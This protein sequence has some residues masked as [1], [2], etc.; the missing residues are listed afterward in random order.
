MA[1]IDCDSFEHGVISTAGGG[2][3]AAVNGAPTIVTGGSPPY[4][5]RVLECLT[6]GVAAAPRVQKNFTASSIVVTGFRYR[7]LTGA[8]MA[9]CQFGS[10][11]RFDLDT[12]NVIQSPFGFD[13]AAITIN[14]W[15]WL[16]MMLDYSTSAGNLLLSWSIDGV[17]QETASSGADATG[18]IGSLKLGFL[19]AQANRQEQFKDL[20]IYT[21]ST[22][23]Y[24]V[25]DTKVL[26]Y[27][28]N[29]VGT[30]NL[31]AATSTFFFKDIA[32]ADTALTTSE[33]TSYQQIDDVPLDADTDHVMLT[34]AT[35]APALPAHQATASHT[36]NP[37][38]APSTTLG[39][40][41]ADDI[42]IGV[43]TN[44][45]A[46]T[47]P[48]FAGT[49]SGGAWTLVDNGQL[50]TTGNVA[51]YWSR[52]T[53]N[54][55]GQTVTSSTTDSGSMCVGRYSGA[56][57]TATPIGATKI[58]SITTN[59]AN[60]GL[61]AFTTTTANSKVVLAVGCDD[62]LAV[63]TAA[64]AGGNAL[65][66]R[67]APSSS[68]GADS[69]VG[70]ADRDQAAAGTSGAF[71]TTW[72]AN[73]AGTG[74]YLLAFE[75]LG[76]PSTTQPTNTWYT[77]HGIADSAE[78]TAPLGVRSIVAIRNDS[79]TTAN[80]II[81]KLRADSAESNIFSGDIASASNLYKTLVSRLTPASNAWTDGLFDAATIRFGYSADADS[82]PRFDAGMLEAVFAVATSTTVPQAMTATATAT[83]TIVRQAGKK[84]TATATAT[85]TIARQIGKTLSSSATATATMLKRVGKSLTANATASSTMLTPKRAVA[86][87]TAN[88]T[89]TAT[90]VRQVGKRVTGNATASATI[91]KQ[92]GK[93]LVANATA[94]ASIAASRAYL[95]ALTA[96]A[97]ATAT[98]SRQVGKFVRADATASATI[99]KQVGKALTATSSATSSLVATFVA[100]GGAVAQFFR[101]LMGV[102]K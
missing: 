68:G 15:Y 60:P 82:S 58:E 86:A 10:G 76:A 44:G 4:G 71:A 63:I 18:T 40:T 22:S 38:T 12:G 46:N 101:T 43:V 5:T 100:G 89:A 52:C 69:Q 91:V 2:L 20:V 39:T 6:G 41:A 102:G 28:P 8:A 34:K 64:T 47:T 65:T 29:A 3:Y 78:S 1:L 94:T 83:A 72:G 17:A 21:G 19:E 32:G 92:V 97:T 81:Y 85:A 11:P 95:L 54:H 16:T 96:S 30:H 50:T 33:T 13:S 98:I 84:M 37:T 62:N 67:A 25:A 36:G 48:T 57:A 61:G 77:E 7:R 45:G 93:T 87:L 51:V 90:M 55:T 59:A 66:V 31:D 14:Q 35:G 70:L 56:L 26:A 24:P 73:A 80:A 42:L 49:Y 88:A 79:G 27:S 53:G 75:L 23:D 99:T 74:K 9:I